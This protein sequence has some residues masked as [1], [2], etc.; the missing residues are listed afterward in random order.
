MRIGH[1]AFLTLSVL[2]PLL[3]ASC[4]DQA[5]P[6]DPKPPVN[7][8]GTCEAQGELVIA[9]GV[10]RDME[11]PINEAHVRLSGKHQVSNQF[12]VPLV[13]WIYMRQELP[14][15]DA[16]WQT[17]NLCEKRRQGWAVWHLKRIYGIFADF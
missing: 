15:A 9:A 13:E 16:G 8:A 10:M 5:L 6:D 3:L 4:S 11:V 2:T 12:A 7:S 17:D 1:L 14:P